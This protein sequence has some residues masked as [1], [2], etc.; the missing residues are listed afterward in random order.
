M[1]K[2]QTQIFS[3]FISN[4]LSE[5]V[6][7]GP[8]RII[9]NFDDKFL[10]GSFSSTAHALKFNSFRGLLL[11]EFTWMTVKEALDC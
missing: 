4:Q 1:W 7:A 8:G 5:S 6:M 10:T 9:A 11:F 2:L 3:N